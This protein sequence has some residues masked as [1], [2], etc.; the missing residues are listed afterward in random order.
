MMKGLPVSDWQ[1]RN[2]MMGGGFANP[3]EHQ[4]G[5]RKTSK[6]TLGSD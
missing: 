4:K 6:K 2:A 1:I 5:I 3:R